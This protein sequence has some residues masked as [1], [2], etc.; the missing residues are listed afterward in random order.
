[1]INKYVDK[2]A[3]FSVSFLIFL[4]SEMFLKEIFKLD[5]SSPYIAGLI[6]TLAGFGKEFYDKHKGGRFD[7]YDILADG[8]G[9]L[10]AIIYYLICVI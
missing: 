9:M 5:N 4:I 6:T 2:I 1:M 3:H 8:L 10:L 7:W